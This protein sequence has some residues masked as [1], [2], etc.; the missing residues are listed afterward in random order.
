MEQDIQDNNAVGEIGDA[1]IY[2]DDFP[3]KVQLMNAGLQLYSHA[4]TDEMINM[5][6]EYYGITI[7]I[8]EA[9]EVEW[10]MLDE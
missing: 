5:Q 3:L 6:E 8:L 9:S 10:T 4:E 2:A 1:S 7:E